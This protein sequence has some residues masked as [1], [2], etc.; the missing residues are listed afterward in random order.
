MAWRHPSLTEDSR[1]KE[2]R[3]DDDENVVRNSTLNFSAKLMIVD[4]GPTAR[5]LL[6]KDLYSLVG[7]VSACLVAGPAALRDNKNTRETKLSLPAEHDK[8]DSVLK[9]LSFGMTPPE[10]GRL[11]D[12]AYYQRNGEAG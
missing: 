7:R 1:Q 6:G 2:A 8:V 3:I 11:L 4:F 9:Q 5:Y 12:N 10:L